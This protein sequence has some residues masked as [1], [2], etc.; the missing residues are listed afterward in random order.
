MREDRVVILARL[1]IALEARAIV[2][3]V[4]VIC[5]VVG[6]VASVKISRVRLLLAFFLAQ[7]F[8]IVLRCFLKVNQSLP[9]RIILLRSCE[10]VAVGRKVHSSDDQLA[11]GTIALHVLRWRLIELL[12]QAAS[13]RKYRLPAAE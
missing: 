1:L 3:R 13:L 12:V 9:V 7:H 8:V 5:L 2:A 10:T 6:R 4:L 11:P